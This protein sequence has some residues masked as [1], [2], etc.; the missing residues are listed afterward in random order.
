MR[1]MFTSLVLTL[2][3]CMSYATGNTYSSNNIDCVDNKS[4]NVVAEDITFT[5]IV[6][7]S[8]KTEISCVFGEN[9][10]KHTAT[11]DGVLVFHPLNYIPVIFYSVDNT[12][13]GEEQLSV[14]QDASSQ[15]YYYAEVLN[16]ETYYFKTGFVMDAATVEVYYDDGSLETGIT[17]KSSYENGDTFYLNGENLE[18]T[19]D[20]DVNIDSFKI[21]YG[22][23]GSVDIPSE[24]IIPN[25]FNNYYCSINLNPTIENLVDEGKLSED[26]SFKVRIEGIADKNNPEILYGEDGSFEISLVLGKL[27]ATVTGISPVSGSNI[28]TYYIEG[29][30]EGIITFTFSEDIQN[31]G[32]V[33]YSYGDAEAGSYVKGALSYQ[34]EGNTVAV[35]IQGITFPE[36]VV[37]TSSGEVQTVVTIAFSSI[38]TINGSDVEP[39]IDGKLLGAMYYVVKENISYSSEITPLDGGSLDNVS[40]IVVW[41]NV[42]IFYDGVELGYKDKEGFDCQKLFTV[43]ECPSVY[44]EDEEG[45]IMTVPL[46]GIEFGAGNVEFEVKNVMLTNGDKKEIKATFTTSGSSSGLQDVLSYGE[47]AVVYDLNGILVT[48]GLVNDII[49]SL[50]KG[51][52]YIVNGKK[53]VVE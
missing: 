51:K 39:N 38:K 32:E 9:Y 2:S 7:D 52:A 15:K 46:K 4:V 20:R 28:N 29:A 6:I 19:I 16:G 47:Y 42:K 8:E 26:E 14:K 41:T 50:E 44:D 36:K 45:Y 3:A 40:E 13:A 43:E 11:K 21:L 37:T 5:D 24:D 35:N 34:I 27:P 49:G 33:S 30:D 18:L 23:G 1:K 17:L 25:F 53:I 10:F 48:E 31:V 22:E 12:G